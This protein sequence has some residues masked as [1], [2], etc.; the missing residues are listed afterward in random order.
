MRLSAAVG[1]LA[2]D[3]PA[4]PLAAPVLLNVA[5]F[6]EAAKNLRGLLRVVVG[7]RA[8]VPELQLRIAGYGPDEALVRAYAAEL[9][10]LADGTVTFLGKLDHAAVAAEMRQA[11]AFVLF[12]NFENLPCV[13][14]EAQASGLPVVATRVGGV[15]ELM[16]EGSHFGQLVAA[17]DEPAL[18]A[19]LAAL[20]ARP[21]KQVAALREQVV[22]RFGYAAVGRQFGEL[23]RRII[24]YD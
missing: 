20:L 9:G 11:A 18:A 15:A 22:A 10:L 13:L 23:Y 17:G 1:Q 3:P 19:A 4:R 14:I 8:T 6:N 16:P 7:L 12:S 21:G 5:A 24:K 2:A